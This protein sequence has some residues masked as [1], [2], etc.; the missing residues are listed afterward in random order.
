MKHHA[1]INGLSE[2]LNGLDLSGMSALI[3]D[4]E[5]DQHSL[6][7]AIAAN[8]ESTTYRAISEMRNLL[9]RHTFLQYTATPQA[10]LLVD[11]ADALSPDWTAL[12]TPGNGYVG[13]ASYFHGRPS[14]LVRRIPE[15]EAQAVE[16][17][18]MEP[19]DSL[20]KAL[21]TF[22]L[23]FAAGHPA[24]EQD[25]P[26]T[27][28]MMVHP[29][30]QIWTHELVMG[31]LREILSRVRGQLRAPQGTPEDSE[32]LEDLDAAYEDLSRTVENLPPLDELVNRLR[33]EIAGLRL[34]EVNSVQDAL[35]QALRW[36]QAYGW[37]LVGG[38][39]LNRGF[40]VKGLTVTYMPRGEGA[41]N[42]DT[43][44]QRARFYGYRSDYLDHCRV[45]LRGSLV[46]AYTGLV[47]TE[48]R[49]R[50]DL[51]IHMRE[52]G[53]L[54]TWKRRFLIDPNLQ[55]TRRSV[56]A[57]GLV[58]AR[59]GEWFAQNYTAMSAEHADTNRALVDGFTSR[60]NLTPL[61]HDGNWGDNQDHLSTTLPLAEA[62]KSLL[63]DWETVAGDR[64]DFEAV[65]IAIS[66]MLAQDPNT[67][68]EI[69]V[70]DNARPRT[71][72]A[73]EADSDGNPRI[74]LMQGRSREEAQLDYPG[75]RNLPR[76]E[77]AKVTVQIH[78]VNV[79]YEVPRDGERPA[80][81]TELPLLAILIKDGV[82][83]WLAQTN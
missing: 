62:Q 49:V 43:L 81:Q 75:D 82:A 36:N 14:D 2:A 13:G 15:H 46:D 59:F 54:K 39:M 5:A 51:E 33:A 7:T 18:A 29:H 19:P 65:H 45:Y 6:N 20:L 10:P 42:A 21:N 22:L 35:S 27:R 70:I 56:V 71:R 77:S 1:H 55:P 8:E 11:L 25:V 4:D 16:Q 50:A 44:A 23:S 34:Q 79:H 37:I 3:V 78:K 28:S 61:R 52:G 68:A 73:T 66:E 17:G 41:G 80:D 30:P 57:V 12:L 48:E 63:V 64:R 74:A 38:E 58:R 60:L 24:Y 26:F 47:D 76:E 67:E 83:A 9:P 31:W 53:S 40:T 69:I 72:R 32:L